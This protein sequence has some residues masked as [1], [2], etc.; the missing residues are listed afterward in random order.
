M[1]L[2]I[3]PTAEMR[4]IVAKTWKHGK[5]CV[6]LQHGW[7]CRLMPSVGTDNELKL[8]R[9]RS[10]CTCQEEPRL[11]AGPEGRAVMPTATTRLFKLYSAKRHLGS[12]QKMTYLTN[13][14]VVLLHWRTV[15]NPVVGQPLKRHTSAAS[16]AGIWRFW[17]HR[18]GRL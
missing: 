1:R 10:L 18:G 5:A 2:V 15:T 9:W 11:Y 12:G 17:R 16:C 6:I 13:I 7:P 4:R 3:S 8:A 14:R